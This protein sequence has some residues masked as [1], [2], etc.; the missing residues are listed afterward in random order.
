ME[1]FEIKSSAQQLM[2]KARELTAI[3]II[4]SDIEEALERLLRSLNTEA[5]LNE[6]GAR[7]MEQRLL[8]VLCNR[9]RMQRD[10]QQHPE[11]NEQ[12]IV[13]PV[14]LTGAGRTGSTKMHKLLAASGDFKY[15]HFWQQYNPSLRTG[16]RIEDPSD[17]VRE[18]DEFIRWF[19]ERTPEAKTIH[20]YETFEPEEETFLFDHTRF[21]INYTLTH[22]CTPSFTQ[23]FMTQ[24]MKPQLEFLKQCVKYLQWQFYPDEDAR[25]WLLKNPQYSGREHLIMQVFPDA[26]LV[27]TH[28]DPGKRIASAAGLMACMQKAY[29]DADRAIALGQQIVEFMVICADQYLELLD[30]HPE[31]KI[32]DIGYTE[33]TKNSELVAEK[34]YAHAGRTLTEKAKQAMRDWEQRNRQHKHGVYKY[35]AADYS[36]TPEMVKERFG[37]Y[38]KRFGQCF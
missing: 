5:L 22:A 4:D 12:K 28:R 24:D 33:L 19:N 1:S 17:R 38:I 11:I 13:R 6:E 34:V 18:A 35:S 23:W 20:H 21:G 10:F 2:S 7:C 14:F 26:V 29:S 15:L 32:L 25:P 37:P 31:L 16:Y 27:A 3:N 36:I 8:T 9:L 30:A